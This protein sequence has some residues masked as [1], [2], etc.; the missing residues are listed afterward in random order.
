VAND[1]I[2]I[3]VKMSA[4]TFEEF[5]AYQKDKASVKKELTKLQSK[6]GELADA[7]TRGF[8]YDG[9]EVIILDKDNAVSAIEQAEDWFE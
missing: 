2:E 3:T 7:V 5:R 8:E 4:E 1:N 9:N 6:F